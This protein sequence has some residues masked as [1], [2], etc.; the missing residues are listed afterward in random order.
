MNFEL[1]VNDTKSWKKFKAFLTV[2]QIIKLITLSLIVQSKELWAVDAGTLQ[3]W[4][5]FQVRWMFKT[6]PFLHSQTSRSQKDFYSKVSVELESTK[7]ALWNPFSPTKMGQRCYQMRYHTV[8][9]FS[10]PKHELRKPETLPKKSSLSGSTWLSVVNFHS[11]IK[12]FYTTYHNHPENI[13]NKNR[14]KSNLSNKKQFAS[15][16]FYRI[17]FSNIESANEKF[18]NAMKCK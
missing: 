13:A 10:L 7:A 6:F 5:C 11:D 1:S 2:Q 9:S 8:M 4:A 3:T 18:M 14:L 15:S 16:F 12:S 17:W